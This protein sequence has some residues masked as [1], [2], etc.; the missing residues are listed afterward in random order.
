MSSSKENIERRDVDVD[1]ICATL[2]GNNFSLN[3]RV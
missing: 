2:E 3:M 1:E